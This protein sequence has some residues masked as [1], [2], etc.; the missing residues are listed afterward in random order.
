MSTLYHNPK[1]YCI[2]VPFSLSVD[3][4]D[5]IGFNGSEKG[6]KSITKRYVVQ[7]IAF[8]DGIESNGSDIFVI[9]KFFF[10]RFDRVLVMQ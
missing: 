2:S 6:H 10:V 8:F 3:P 4:M 1:K 7:S 5:S 9:V